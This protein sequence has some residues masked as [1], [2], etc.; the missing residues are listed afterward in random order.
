M[1]NVDDPSDNLRSFSF[2]KD[3]TFSL[4]KIDSVTIKYKDK[5]VTMAV[6]EIFATLQ[7][8]KGLLADSD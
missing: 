4:D 1:N 7:N 6:E 3:F 2:P 8:L 5:K